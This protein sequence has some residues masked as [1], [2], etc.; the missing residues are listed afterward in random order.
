MIPNDSDTAEYRANVSFKQ[1]KEVMSAMENVPLTISYFVLVFIGITGNSLVVS[2]VLKNRNM[3]STTNILLAFVSAADL[4]S[5]ICFIPFAIL[6][7]FKLPGGTLGAVLCRTFATANTSSA[8]I[9]VSITTLTLL[10]VERFRALLKPWN[11]RLRLTKDSVFYWIFGISLY[12]FILVIPLFSFM[13]FDE[14]ERTCSD[15]REIKTERRI[16]YSLLGCGVALALF[17]ICFCYWR[18]IRGF[19]FGSQRLCVNEELQQKRKVVKLLLLITLAFMICFTPR[20]VYFLFFYSNRGPFNQISFFL[21]HC[22]SATNPIILWFQSQ[23]FRAEF[24]NMVNEINCKIK[25]LTCFVSN[26]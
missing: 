16:Y 4:I 2:A 3:R 14:K 10:A 6:L 13:E 12:S 18:I 15:L 24:K 26:D 22:N 23:N 11:S 9:V 8:T 25:R 17:V 7:T 19:Y 20:A 21:I 1:G 5:L